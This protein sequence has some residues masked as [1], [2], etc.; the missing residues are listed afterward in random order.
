[1]IMGI[2]LIIFNSVFGIVT[3]YLT[4]QIFRTHRVYKIRCKWIDTDDKRRFK[5]SYEYMFNPS[6]HNLY[7]FKFPKDKQFN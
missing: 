3:L 6:M 4:Y 7:G 2:I 1:M 5:Y